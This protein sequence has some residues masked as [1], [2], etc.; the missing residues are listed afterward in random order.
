MKNEKYKFRFEENDGKFTQSDLDK[1]ADG[2]DCTLR[3]YIKY[4]MEEGYIEEAN[5]DEMQDNEICEAV[6]WIEYLETK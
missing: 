4:G 3:E 6:D 1:I 2:W 5:I